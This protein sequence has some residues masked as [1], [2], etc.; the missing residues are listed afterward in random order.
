[1]ARR[2]AAVRV[3]TNGL[4]QFTD[5]LSVYELQFQNLDLSYIE[6]GSKALQVKELW[7]QR[8]TNAQPIS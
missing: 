7:H 8:K 1:M 6:E 5:A 3:P 2:A 4:K